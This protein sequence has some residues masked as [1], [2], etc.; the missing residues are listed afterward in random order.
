M[1]KIDAFPMLKTVVFTLQNGKNLTAAMELL[2]QNAQKKREKR[3]YSNILKY[4]QEG[5]SF[6][7]ALDKYCVCSS[8][9]VYF[10]SMA[11]KGTDFKKSLANVVKYI[12]TKEN[13]QQE[14]SDKLTVVMIYFFLA[15]IV[16][17]VVYFIA[18]P[19]QFQRAQGYSPEVLLLIESHLNVAK[20]LSNILLFLLMVTAFYFFTTTVSM[21]SKDRLFHSISSKVVY[22]LPFAKKI[23]LQFE[24]FIIFMMLSQML[25]S[26]IGIKKALQATLQRGG[27]KKFQK[28]F[29]KMLGAISKEGVLAL[30]KEVFDATEQS[31]LQG[32]GSN[33]QMGESFAQIATRAKYEAMNLSK[34]F[35]RYI[36]LM[37]VL[38][39]AF[40]VFIEFYV[41]VLTQLL[42]QKGL[43]DMG[44]SGVLF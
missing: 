31:I 43:V 5:R 7:Q 36:T 41:V 1:T 28:G 42:L 11:E 18:L 3:A 32:V 21:F 14:S 40:A 15:V 25:H 34:R 20:L 26:G 29:D 38:L 37:A 10:V 44:N 27:S 16:V 6:S 19:I 23:V 17:T 8:E 24:K 39:M 4:L 35:F 30:P 12:Q 2:I 33:R 22:R 9:V 13:F